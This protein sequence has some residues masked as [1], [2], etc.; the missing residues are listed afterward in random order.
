MLNNITNYTNLI[1]NRK[2]RTLLDAT[3]LFTI[4]VRDANFY[5]N[6]QPALITAN[7]LVNSVA[8]L[9][10]PAAA[11]WG[12]ISGNINTQG[13]LISLLNAKQDTITLTTT[14][15]SGAATLIGSTLNIPNYA[16]STLPAWLEYNA[17]DLTIWNNG[18]GNISSNT[19]FGITAFGNNTTGFGNSTYG[20]SALS[21]NTVGINNTSIGGYSLLNN[22]TGSSNVAIGGGASITNTLGNS[23]VVIG[24]GAGSGTIGNGNTVIGTNSFA[25]N[26]SGC[27]LIGANA[28]LPTA[29]NQ[30]VVGSTVT[31]A[32]T[33]AAEVNTSTNVWN[34]V[35]NGVARKILLA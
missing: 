17:T 29:N 22:T 5:G 35:I 20:I 26:F 27:V 16:G 24:Y 28:A 1:S 6:Y 10:P 15:S 3:D 21:S 7:D 32:G 18:K 34:V 11:A 8:S 4:G 31:N 23:N 12:S 13:D 30:F 9:L 25:N 33:V 14:G 19:S 2:V